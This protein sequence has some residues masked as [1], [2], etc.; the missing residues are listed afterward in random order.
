[1][2]LIPEGYYNAVAVESPNGDGVMAYAH[3]C[4]AK[5]GTK[6]VA[7]RFRITDGA[8]QGR[9]FTW[10]G[11]FTT[12]S[13]ERTAESLR[14]CGFKG[15]DILDV[16]KQELRQPV[17][18]T[19][20][21]DNYSDDGKTRVKVAWVNALGGGA[22]RIQQL[23]QAKR[24]EFRGLM[25]GKLDSVPEHDAPAVQASAEQPRPDWGNTGGASDP[26]DDVPF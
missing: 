15:S 10:F 1:M 11:T 19:L 20:E 23:D 9:T 24:A 14:Y 5:T 26:F 12:K 8:Y 22:I 6:Q 7:V 18:I 3:L 2:E 21:H 13:W 25:Q 16:E 4:E 17:N